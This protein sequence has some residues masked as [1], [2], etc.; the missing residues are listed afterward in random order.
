MGD[1]GGGDLTIVDNIGVSRSKFA[2]GLVTRSNDDSSGHLIAFRVRS[3]SKLYDT[4]GTVASDC[5]NVL[6]TCKCV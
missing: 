2:S 1:D 4:D 5:Y 3:D 6:I